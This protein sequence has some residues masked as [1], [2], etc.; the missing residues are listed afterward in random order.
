M[1]PATPAALSAGWLTAALRDAGTIR[2]SVVTDVSAEIIG[3]DRGFTGVVARVTPGY[4]RSEP[5]QP[6]TL[7]AKFP[8]A[9]HPGSTYHDALQVDPERVRQH[10]ERCAREVRFYRELAVGT[11]PAPRTFGAWADETTQGML[12]LLE[13]LSAGVPGDALLGCSIDEV[14]LVV[15]QVARVHAGWWGQ[16]DRPEPSWLPRWGSDPAAMAARFVQRLGPVLDRYRARI[17]AGVV[18]LVRELTGGYESMLRDLA[19]RPTTIIHGDLHLDNLIFGGAKGVTLLDWQSV[20]VGPIVID[21]GLFLVNSLSVA[22][23][24][25]VEFDILARYH[26]SLEAGGV[27]GY[28]LDDLIDDYFRSIA[29]QLAGIVGWLAR[30]DLETLAGR[31]RALVDALFVPGQIFAACA[32]HAERL[33]TLA[34]RR[35]R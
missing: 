33:A 35:L 23:R 11:D 7:I 6:A 13:D 8:M 32:D 24:R 5:G 29:W 14:I 19:Q 15:D 10:W 1:I 16:T 21:L 20:A 12:L 18:Q 22:D 28:R 3:A 27:T 31:E 9:P 26:R 4:D 34:K 25:A 2:E 17:P 30:V